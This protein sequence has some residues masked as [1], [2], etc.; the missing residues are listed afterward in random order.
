MTSPPFCIWMAVF[1]LEC[2]CLTG[3]TVFIETVTA[4]AERCFWINLFVFLS[5]LSALF[6]Q[7]TVV[8]GDADRSGAQYRGYRGSQPEVGGFY[9]TWHRRSKQQLKVCVLLCSQ[10]VIIFIRRH[11]LCCCYRE[12]LRFTSLFFPRALF[13]FFFSF[14]FESDERKWSM[15]SRALTLAGSGMW[16]EC[17]Y[18]SSVH[19]EVQTIET[20]RP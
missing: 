8:R 9:L 1:L 15:A 2:T 20:R 14:Y 5:S 19:D 6:A 4:Q 3:L 16:P 13:F 7:W 18:A 17:I 12:C 11:L 10:R